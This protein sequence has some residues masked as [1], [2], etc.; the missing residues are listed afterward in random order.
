MKT[1]RQTCAVAV[2][3]LLL[4]V[5]ALA[6]QVNCP[7]VADPPPPPAETT[8]TSSVTASLILALVSLI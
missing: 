6:G 5:P 3:A 7:G 8:V 4:S 2:L 1:L